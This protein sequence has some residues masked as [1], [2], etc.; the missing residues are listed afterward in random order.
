MQQEGKQTSRT[1]GEAPRSVA[2]RRPRWLAPVNSCYF[3][4]ADAVLSARLVGVVGVAE[5]RVTA[6]ALPHG[7]A[8]CAPVIINRCRSLPIAQFAPGSGTASDRNENEYGGP[9][10]LP[11]DVA[12]DAAHPGYGLRSLAPGEGKGWFAPCLNLN[13]LP[14]SGP[15]PSSPGP[16]NPLL[17]KHMPRPADWHGPCESVSVARFTLITAAGTPQP[18]T[19]GLPINRDRS[20]GWL[21]TH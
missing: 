11:P 13:Q 8:W 12:A 3:P 16:E 9:S 5:G 20:N 15:T 1:S 4:R 17:R 7:E 2:A 14:R 6:R 19:R 10:K 21:S 18:A